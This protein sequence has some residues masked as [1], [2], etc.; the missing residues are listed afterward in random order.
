MLVGLAGR[1][2]TSPS[3]SEEATMVEEEE[4]EPVG[5]KM[6]MISREADSAVCI[7]GSRM[8]AVSHKSVMVRVVKYVV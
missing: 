8:L 4:T 1:V 3:T 7:A 2:V 6:V 5:G